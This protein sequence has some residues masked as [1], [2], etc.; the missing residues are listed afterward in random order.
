MN[1]GATLRQQQA[2]ADG[3]LARMKAKAHG[4]R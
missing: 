3:K 4:T 1:V 2:V